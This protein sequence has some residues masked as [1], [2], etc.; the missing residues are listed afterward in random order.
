MSLDQPGVFQSWRMAVKVL[1]G[2]IAFGL[3]VA[4]AIYEL[5]KW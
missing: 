4:A 5:A 1:S 3:L 2:C